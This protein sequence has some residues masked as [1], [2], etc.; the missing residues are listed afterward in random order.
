[1][2]RRENYNRAYPQNNAGMIMTSL[3]REHSPFKIVWR[4]NKS[5]SL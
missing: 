1:M 2:N 4:E 5:D 3:D